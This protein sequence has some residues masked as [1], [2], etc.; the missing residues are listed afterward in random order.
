MKYFH[1]QNIEFNSQLNLENSFS[2]SSGISVFR[3]WSAHDEPDRF[4]E[5]S[6]SF[7]SW[8]G[9]VFHKT[10]ECLA[11]THI[12]GRRKSVVAFGKLVWVYEEYEPY[13]MV[14]LKLKD[15]V[16]GDDH[17]YRSS[18]GWIS[19]SLKPWAISLFFFFSFPD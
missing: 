17:L 18:I 9:L 4:P 19:R 1:S 13:Y 11:V 12:F 6:S 10:L 14:N 7:D 8:R 3:P 2:Y 5:N 16:K 15:W